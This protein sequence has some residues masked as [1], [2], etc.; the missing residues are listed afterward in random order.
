MSNSS[1]NQQTNRRVLVVGKPGAGYEALSAAFDKFGSSTVLISSLD[2]LRAE[3]EEPGSI[4]FIAIDTGIEAHV[5]EMYELVSGSPFDIEMFFLFD[6]GVASGAYIPGVPESRS[7]NRSDLVKGS[8]TS[9][10]EYSPADG[11]GGH[12]SGVQTEFLRNSYLCYTSFATIKYSCRLMKAC[13]FWWEVKGQEISV[14]ERVRKLFNR[15]N[16]GLVDVAANGRV[17]WANKA[18]ENMAGAGDLSGRPVT[19]FVDERD[20]ACVTA[21]HEQLSSG[22]I[23]P[24]VFRLRGKEGAVKVDV[25]PR[26]DK[27]GKYVGHVALVSFAKVSEEEFVASRNLVTLYGLAL[28]LS[29]AYDVARIINII[30]ETLREVCG[31]RYC[32][33]KLKGFGEVVEHEVDASMNGELK[34]SLDSFCTRLGPQSIRVIKDLKRDP[35]PAAAVIGRYDMQ[36]VVCVSL[37]AGAERM[38]Y[39]WALAD[40]SESLSREN[41]SFLISVGI[42]A[43]LALQNA[44]NVKHRLEEETSRRRFYRDALNAL[45]SGKLVFCERDELDLHWD[46][47]G[48]EI[49]SMVLAD[50][51]DV[52]ASR[53]AADDMM[54]EQGFD[55]DRCFDMATCVSEAAT[56]VVKYGPPGKMS[57][58]V[59]DDAVHVRLDDTGPGISFT[60]LPKAVL[61]SGFSMGPNP[62]L[63]LGYSVML[64]MCD[65]VY[66]CTGDQIGTSLILEMSKVKADPL[67]AFVGF[68]DLVSEA[69]LAELV[70]NVQ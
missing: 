25:S 28:R 12:A 18:F 11:D 68:K 62:S 50:K 15:I 70:K 35:D 17:I 37:S 45:T 16:Q 38:G 65:C 44:V 34:D 14:H 43:G 54:R 55:K 60:N 58:R 1:E 5:D 30:T 53:K 33:I 69:D 64:E 41:N 40:K 9:E 47:C 8:S 59:E 13:G 63:G 21:V 46:Q 10:D 36:G 20:V 2:E 67:D 22:I 31:Y 56:N 3:L 66:L 42:Q 7:W 6:G 48:T 4:Q 32:G 52:P 49:C 39:I 24:F 27:S 61:L 57:I 29:R 23:S 51:A 19:E 26:L